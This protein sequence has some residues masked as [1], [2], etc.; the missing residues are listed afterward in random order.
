MWSVE[1]PGRGLGNLMT[2][3]LAK[4]AEANCDDSVLDRT[5][6]LSQKIGVAWELRLSSSRMGAGWAVC[7]RTRIS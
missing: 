4:P 3:G 2:E 5:W 1:E 7:L 6:C